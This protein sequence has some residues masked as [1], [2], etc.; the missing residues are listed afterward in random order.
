M[1]EFPIMIS[2][3]SV[4]LDEESLAD[5]QQQN[6]GGEPLDPDALTAYDPSETT[7]VHQNILSQEFIDHL[8]QID[9]QAASNLGFSYL[10]NLNL[11]REVEGEAT[12][13]SLN[14]SATGQSGPMASNS[15][16]STYP[17]S[18]NPE[19]PSILE[20]NYDVLAGSL[21]SADTDMVL[22]VDSQNRVDVNL[23]ASLGFDT[24]DIETVAFEDLIGLEMQWIPNDLYYEQTSFGTYIPAQD[25]N[26][27]AEA[28]DITL[29]LS[30]I[31]RLND[32]A[33]I[34]LL[35]TGIVYSDALVQRLIDL[36]LDSEIARAQQESDVS[37]F[38]LEP[39]EEESKRQ[40][41]AYIGASN[42]PYMITVYPQNF[43]TKDQVLAYLDAY[44]EGKDLA[45]RVVYVDLASTLSN[46]TQGIMD[47]ITIVLIAFAAISLVV[48]L[49]M[50]GIITYTSVIERTKEIGILKALGARKKDITRVFD[51]ETF[52]L[53][54]F[55]GSL[56]IAIA[57][58]LTLPINA[59]LYQMTELSDVAQLKIDHALMLVVISTVLTMIGG[60][61]PA[62]IASNKDAVV[63]LRS[64]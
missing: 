58:L 40:L 55:S 36:S 13:V 41:L 7:L 37:V 64:E 47:G 14:S 22:V 56:G 45:D 1:S 62:K 61:I 11:V 4:N 38:T 21:P 8:N 43:E 34:T 33:Q 27:M 5:L 29:T 25:L 16:L 19:E 30:G 42:E 39:L 6:S 50:I 53:G 35:N 28:S 26:A 10:M 59:I 20:K 23:L 18:L 9:P 17:I 48:S 63:A 52:I 2:Q 24:D 51:A 49:I 12:L 46:L 44:N 31:V 54:V 3:S 57:Y 60:H 15:G 32:S